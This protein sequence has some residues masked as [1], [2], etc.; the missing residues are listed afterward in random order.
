MT[1]TEIAD[2]LGRTK[3]S[4]RHGI[5]GAT[6]EIKSDLIDGTHGKKIYKAIAADEGD[7]ARWE[8]MLSNDSPTE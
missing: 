4:I 5:R 6:G 3:E 7:L 2:Q 1:I 8:A